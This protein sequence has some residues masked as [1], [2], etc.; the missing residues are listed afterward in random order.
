MAFASFDLFPQFPTEIRDLIWDTAADAEN[1]G[2]V[3]VY[4]DRQPECRTRAANGAR[5]IIWQ[6]RCYNRNPSPLHL[7]SHESREQY[8]LSHPN[9]LRLNQGQLIYFNSAKNTVY[10]DSES[11]LNLWHY[12][13]RH[14]VQ[15]ADPPQAPGSGF[16]A[17]NRLNGFSQIRTLGWPEGAD[18][19]NIVGLADLRNPVERA[20][21]GLT[22]IRLLGDRGI[23]PGG[24][25]PATLP[26][27]NRSLQRRLIAAIITKYVVYNGTR[28]F[29]A[30]AQAV[31]N[32]G[33][34]R[35]IPDVNACRALKAG[36]LD[37]PIA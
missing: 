24:I 37:I 35:V 16:V 21:S 20:L 19:T 1:D 27:A 18:R 26:V 3:E 29:N 5:H 31:I 4:F 9:I 23:H 32:A 22:N 8:L 14:R 15:F 7:V 11:F 36:D 25:D 34:G 13:K 17:F 33:R 12:V 30:D 6:Y 10:F 2:V 28:V